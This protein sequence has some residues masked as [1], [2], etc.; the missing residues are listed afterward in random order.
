MKLLC[1]LLASIPAV[2][3]AGNLQ[4]DDRRPKD[5]VNL[6]TIAPEIQS[7][8]RYFTEHNFVGQ[9]IESYDAP[10]CLLTSKTAQALKSVQDRLLP[11]GL[12]LKVYDC[13]RPQS[14]VDDFA[15]WAKNLSSMEMRTEFYPEV[16]KSRLF[17]DGYIAY[18]SGHSRG[19]T[20]D[21]TIVPA[22]SQ[23]PAYDSKRKQVSCTSPAS[24]RAPDN[25]LDFGTGFDCF[26]PL[27]H[28]DSQGVSPQQRAN[29]LLLQSLMVQAGFKPL[30][31]EW[32]HFTLA[33]EPYPD[34]YFNF[35]VAD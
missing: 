35:P 30:D 10:V 26:S 13:Y 34:T 3:I 21:L 15:R 20:V 18:R 23:I 8:L 28:P 2:C 4:V 7:D 29:R 32:W 25:S 12:T 31:T 19:S 5:F 11:M 27:S 24:Q 9:R 6:N 14:A 22:D 33:K 16:E 1:A 17:S